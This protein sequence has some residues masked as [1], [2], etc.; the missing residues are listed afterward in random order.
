[1]PTYSVLQ[2]YS[3]SVLV[4]QGNRGEEKKNIYFFLLSALGGECIA[5]PEEEIHVHLRSREMWLRGQKMNLRLLS[6]SGISLL[7][8]YMNQ[9]G[10]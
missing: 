5:C 7:S 8:E 2:I 9:N 1:M 3:G 6:L 10:A 4:R